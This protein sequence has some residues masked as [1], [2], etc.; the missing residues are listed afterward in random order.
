[1]TLMHGSTADSKHT[2]PSATSSR[3]AIFFAQR[4]AAPRLRLP[5]I[6]DRATGIVRLGAAVIG[7]LGGGRLR[8]GREVLQQHTLARQER[9]RGAVREEARQMAL[10]DQPVIHRETARD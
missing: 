3:S 9:L 8:V 7:D 4:L 6:D 5:Q 2:T 10:E 1:M